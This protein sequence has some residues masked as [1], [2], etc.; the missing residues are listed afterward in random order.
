MKKTKMIKKQIEVYLELEKACRLI[1]P[2]LATG[3]KITKREIDKANE[4]I[5][6]ELGTLKNNT[7]VGRVYV[8]LVKDYFKQV[9]LLAQD[10][11]IT[12]NEL[13]YYVGSDSKRISLDNETCS[14][15][16]KEYKLYYSDI[17]DRSEKQIEQDIAEY[18]RL[19]AE[20]EALKK[21]QSEIPFY[22]LIN[23]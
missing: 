10:R 17:K 4:L 15:N 9:K 14:I 16:L 21:K 22:Y 20:I 6:K 3:K 1:E 23:N 5:K 12:D 2:I 13:T 18:E 8:Y 11:S 7:N 19:S